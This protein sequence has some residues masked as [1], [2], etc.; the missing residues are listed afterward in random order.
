MSDTVYHLVLKT[1]TLLEEE[2]MQRI[3]AAQ[4]AYDQQIQMIA[5]QI[6]CAAIRE[7]TSRGEVLVGNHYY[8]PENPVWVQRA[9]SQN[10]SALEMDSPNLK[11]NFPKCQNVF[12]SKASRNKY[13]EETMQ[14]VKAQQRV[15]DAYAK[16]IAPQFGKT[17]SSGSVKPSSSKS[18]SG[19]VYIGGRKINIQ[20]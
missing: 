14:N 10:S 11:V 5:E 18:P 7:R 15:N 13:C 2:E 6:R 20:R 9:M 1:R 16:A 12:K 19:S 3:Q 8:D 17:S 4:Q